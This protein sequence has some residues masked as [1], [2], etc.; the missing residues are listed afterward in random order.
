M[1]ALIARPVRALPARGRNNYYCRPRSNGSPSMIAN[2]R[3][4]AVVTPIHPS[5]TFEQ[6]QG[7]MMEKAHDSSA[8]VCATGR[9]AVQP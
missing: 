2:T 7:S 8:S 4:L 3:I 9:E 1:A 6:S 5:L